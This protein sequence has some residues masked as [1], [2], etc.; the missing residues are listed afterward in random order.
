M[1]RIERSAQPP[2][3]GRPALGS[4]LLGTTDPDRLRAWYCT[5]FAPDHSG[6]GFIDF[7]GTELL[8]DGRSDLRPRN[9]EPGRTILNFHVDDARAMEDRLIA[10][11]AIWIRELEP[12]DAGYLIGTV[13]DPDGNYVQIIQAPGPAP[14]APAGPV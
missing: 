4:V 11:D 9:T 13:L 5:V 1:E 12:T 8:I 2:E 7:G 3:R 14:G 6:E 10:L